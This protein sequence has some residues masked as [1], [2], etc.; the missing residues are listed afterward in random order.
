MQCHIRLTTLDAVD[1]D[2]VATGFSNRC[3]HCV[4]CRNCNPTASLKC[5][6]RFDARSSRV[7]FAGFPALVRISRQSGVE[8]VVKENSF[9][10]CTD[11][12]ICTNRN[13]SS[14]PKTT[15]WRL[16]A[17]SKCVHSAGE[18]CAR[19]TAAGLYR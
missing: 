10:L 5:S 2:V 15:G 16:R 11:S 7:D 19:N 17:R 18:K 1:W 13:L 14:K 12:C 6:I 4:V 9:V 3:I 8:C